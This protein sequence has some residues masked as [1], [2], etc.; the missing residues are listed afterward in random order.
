M[1]RSSVS[2]SVVNSSRG[3]PENAESVV[4]STTRF[5]R[6]ETI[7]LPRASRVTTVVQCSAPACTNAC[8]CGCP[9]D[10]SRPH[11]C[12]TALMRTRDTAGLARKCSASRDANV[13]TWSIGSC[14]A[15]A[16]TVFFIV[17]VARHGRVVAVD[18]DRVER[19]LELHVDRQVD[20]LVRIASRR[21]L[22]SRMR[23]LPYGSSSGQTSSDRFTAS[24]DGM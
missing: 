5:A 9:P 16:Y 17:S 11:G 4:F 10:D 18:V 14:R 15:S 23:D 21:T 6:P 1:M 7:S 8:G 24:G 13:S 19:A 2:G 22:T 12:S 20:E 3:K